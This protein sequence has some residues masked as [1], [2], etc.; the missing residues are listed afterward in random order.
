MFFGLG[1]FFSTLLG[2]PGIPEEVYKLKAM[3][4][5]DWPAKPHTD[6][7]GNYLCTD[8][9]VYITRTREHCNLCN[10]CIDD[11]DHHCVFY[12]KSIGGGNIMW[13]RLSLIGFI[14]NMT[15]FVIIYGFIAM[16]GAGKA[17]HKDIG[18]EYN[19]QGDST[20]HL[21]ASDD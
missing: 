8:C 9:H 17:G 20:R 7:K 5:C 3:S 19:R 13:F 10:V 14:I 18:P 12:S 21:L 1:M 4:R 11:L 6:D 15:Y 16:K 2:N